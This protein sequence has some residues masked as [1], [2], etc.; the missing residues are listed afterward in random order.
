MDFESF[1]HL[2][3]SLSLGSLSDE[4]HLWCA[5]LDLDPQNLHVLH[6]LL[7]PDELARAGRYYFEK[8]RKYFIARR[9]LLRMIL[10]AYLSIAP[11]QLQFSYGPFGKP[12]LTIEPSSQEIQFNL[13]HSNDLAAYVVS[14]NR[15]VGVDI[16]YIRTIPE[17]THIAEQFFSPYERNLIHSLPIEERSDAFIKIW[18]CKEAFLKA[19]GEGLTDS[20][21]QIEVLFNQGQEDQLSLNHGDQLEA[22]SWLLEMVRDIPGYIAVVVAE[23]P[24]WK[25]NIKNVS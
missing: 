18:A 12:S 24:D 5:S 3:S 17:A 22:S 9:G 20:L 15:R 25:I 1:S 8:H 13:S 14:R 11:T 6:S 7:A 4:V 23:G 2:Q 10:S 16:E 19:T 21:H